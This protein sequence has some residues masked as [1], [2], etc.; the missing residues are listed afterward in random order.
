MRQKT[1]IAASVGLL[2]LSSQQAA[3]GALSRRF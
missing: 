1:T 2:W 3:V